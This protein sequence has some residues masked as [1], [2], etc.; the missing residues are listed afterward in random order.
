[1]KGFIYKPRS[2]I[3]LSMVLIIL[4]LF[5]FPISASPSQLETQHDVS[6]LVLYDESYS[7]YVSEFLGLD[8]EDRLEQILDYACLSFKNTFNVNLNYN[9]CTYE[10]C[11]GAPFSVSPEF[12]DTCI[13][14]WAWDFTVTPP[15]RIWNS[16]SGYCNCTNDSQCYVYGSSLGH[17]TSGMRLLRAMYDYRAGIVNPDFDCI[18][19][20]VGHK[21]CLWYNNSHGYCGG[22]TMPYSG[23]MCSV[24]S[25]VQDH[26][27][28]PYQ[29]DYDD[30]PNY[31]L[32]TFHVCNF[33]SNVKIF[34]HE[35]SHI[36]GANDGCCTS[37]SPCI[38]SGGFD[39]IVYVNNLWCSQCTS[40]FS[41][42]LFD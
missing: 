36:F 28:V 26:N 27:Q 16:V 38:M 32:S 40:D 6:M 29:V 17:H 42:D 24:V 33:L 14:L 21:V 10:N 25:G 19:T 5:S 18:V 37:D 8:P 12:P 23:W 1:M 9:I 20:F 39:G 11:I 15:G 41:P 34:Q 4:F 13:N 30:D 7:V 3:A 35:V 2:M 31:D 22:A